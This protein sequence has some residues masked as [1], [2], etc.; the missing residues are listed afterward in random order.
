MS[1]RSPDPTDVLV[2]RNIR[3]QRLARRMSQTVL[4]TSIGITFQ[5]VQKYELGVNR[6]GS[7]RLA[8]VAEVFGLPIAAL[9]EGTP[10]KRRRGTEASVLELVSERGPIRLVQAFARIKDRSTRRA[11]ISLVESVAGVGKS[12]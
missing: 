7:G 6:V 5:Q 4:A 8:R 12:N 10:T 3:A 9:F 11:I 1:A 2:G